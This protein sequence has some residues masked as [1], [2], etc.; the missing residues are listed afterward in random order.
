[1]IAL[2]TGSGVTFDAAGAAAAGWAGRGGSAR[3]AA[4]GSG[5]GA[6][7]FVATGNQK[8]KTVPRPRSDCTATWPSCF[9]TIDHTTASPSPVLPCFVLK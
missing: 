1:M 4:A 6:G 9:W 5:R 2:R 7:G 3:G 8:V